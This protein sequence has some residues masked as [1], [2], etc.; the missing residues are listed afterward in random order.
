[1]PI[2][3]DG[4]FHGGFVRDRGEAR[5]VRVARAKVTELPVPDPITVQEASLVLASTR[6]FPN[7]KTPLKERKTKLACLGIPSDILDKGSQ[8]YARCVRLA[9]SYKRTR[10]KEMFQAHGYVSSGVHS[11]LASA[12]LAL[13]ASRFLYAAAAESGSAN[14]QLLKLASGLG[15]S[16][17][18]N[19]LSAWELCH[20]EGIVKKKIAD[21]QAMTPWV[22]TMQPEEKRKPGRP[23]NADRKPEETIGLL[24]PVSTGGQESIGLAGDGSGEEPGTA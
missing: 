1:M 8:E 7:R 11:L 20:R 4:G 13:S 14:P 5:G 15:D 3:E 10:V 19:E 21:S 16:A 12:S 17:R 9:N 23:R 22:L 18:Q 24:Q 2:Q 6:Q